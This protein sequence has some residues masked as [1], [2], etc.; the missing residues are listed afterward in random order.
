MTARL[1]YLMRGLPSCGKSWTARQL[2]GSDGVV[3]ETDRYFHTEVGDDPTQYDFNDEL[4]PT[5]RDWIFAQFVESI[6]AERSPI[7]LDRGNGRNEETRRF[8]AY[9]V[10]NDYVVQLRE[11]DSPW[12][13]ELSVLLKYRQFL[14]PQVLDTWAQRLSTKS[15]STHRVPTVTIRRWMNSWK[16]DLSVDDILGRTSQ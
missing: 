16:S 9:A 12:W 2:A 7:V 11:P 4:L 14:D 5:A 13:Q 6:R 8:A 15:R 10:A 3:L 1:V